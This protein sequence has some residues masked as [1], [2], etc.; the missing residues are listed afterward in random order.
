MTLSPNWII[1]EHCDSL[2]ESVP[3][4]K[5]QTSQCSRCGAVLER[6]QHLNVQQLLALSITAALLFVFANAFPVIGISLEGLS[7]EATLWQSVEALAQGRISLIA[8][9]TG[10]AII[11]APG[12]QIALLCWVLGFANIG[13]AAPGFKACMRA[14]EHL[15]PWSMLE[16]CLLGILVAIVKLAG[17]LD[18][19]PGLGLWSLAMLT[20]LI[21]LISGKGIRRLWTD[22]EGRY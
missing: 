9:V 8:A 3:L 15:R 10:L 18:V 13:R 12:L 7:N 16:V 4:A 19:H 6:A 20:V 22:L 17:M 14:L 1:C 11:L 5:G 21:I 2:Y